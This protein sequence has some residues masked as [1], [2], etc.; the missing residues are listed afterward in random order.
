M[1]LGADHEG[2]V[3]SNQAVYQLDE[4]ASASQ[5]TRSRQSTLNI[6]RLSPCKRIERCCASLGILTSGKLVCGLS[7]MPQS[8]VYSARRILE[9]PHKY[10]FIRICF[11]SSRY[12]TNGIS[13]ALEAGCRTA[14]CSH[15]YLRKTS[16]LLQGNHS[17]LSR[18][19]TDPSRSPYDERRALNPASIEHYVRDILLVSRLHSVL[20]DL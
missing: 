5:G 15:C 7:S 9:C 8:D 2:R 17:T 1:N 16:I 6:C 19:I 10:A 14:S 20:K 12:S 18:W 3:M 4:Q 13:R 11:F